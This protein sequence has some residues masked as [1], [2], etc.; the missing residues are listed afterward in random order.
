MTWHDDAACL[1]QGFTDE[2]FQAGGRGT[3]EMRK[4]C[5]DCPVARDCFEWAL[6]H[7]RWGY[8]AGTTEEMRDTYRKRLNISVEEPNAWL[9]RRPP[10]FKPCG[11]RAAAKAHQRKGEPLCSACVAAESERR[12]K[13]KERM[14]K[15]SA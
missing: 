1:E 14:A 4:L 13:Y 11:T 10:E 6:H 15:G 7:E 9:D 8:W 2:W 3:R 12:R 5:T